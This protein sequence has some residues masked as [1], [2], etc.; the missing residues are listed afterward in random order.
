MT[1]LE[2]WKDGSASIQMQRYMIQTAPRYRIP[3]NTAEYERAYGKMSKRGRKNVH[4]NMQKMQKRQHDYIPRLF[5]W[6]NTSFR[7]KGT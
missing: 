1:V 3:K 2:R 7:S 6:R 4:H 5:V